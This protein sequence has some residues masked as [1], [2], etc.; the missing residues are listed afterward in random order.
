VEYSEDP[1]AKSNQGDLGFFEA[2]RMVKPFADAAFAMSTPGEISEP[3]KTN[4]GYHIIQFHEKKPKTV[5]S[6]EEVKDKIIQGEREKFLADYRKKYLAEIL[7]DPSLKLNEEAADRF[8][9][10]KPEAPA[11]AEPKPSQTSKP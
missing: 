5:R 1:S 6:F 9:T 10:K 7:V 3:V 2:K 11:A 8:L 4:F